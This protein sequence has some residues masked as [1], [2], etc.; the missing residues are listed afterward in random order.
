MFLNLI[1]S[2]SFPILTLLL[3]LLQERAGKLRHKL[4]GSVNKNRPEQS[5]KV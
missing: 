2:I 5:S 1:A 4:K 3:L